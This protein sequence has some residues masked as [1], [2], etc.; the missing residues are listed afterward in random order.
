MAFKDNVK[1]WFETDKYPTQ[2]QFYQKIDW[3]RWKDEL[4]AEGDLTPALIA[5]IN[6][7]SGAYRPERK[8]VTGNTTI[9]MGAEFRLVNIAIN[10]PSSYALEFHINR[11]GGSPGTPWLTMVV[12]ALTKKDFLVSNQQVN[13]TFW[14]DETINLTE[15]SGND[16]SSTPV[17]FL[18]DRR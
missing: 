18:I 15:V 16:F 9:V 14:V 7:I 3:L 17:I 4:I 1:P 2:T 10:N 6:A 12:P 13:N 11:I 5:K 8:E